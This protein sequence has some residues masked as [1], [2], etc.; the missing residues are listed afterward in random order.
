MQYSVRCAGPEFWFPRIE[1]RPHTTVLSGDQIH[2]VYRCSI[3]YGP[4]ARVCV[5]RRIPLYTFEAL[6]SLCKSMEC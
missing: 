6:K 1:L 2:M 5:R 3:N 4:S